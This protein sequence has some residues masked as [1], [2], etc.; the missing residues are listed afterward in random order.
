MNKARIDLQ[1]MTTSLVQCGQLATIIAGLALVAQGSLAAE[2]A[3]YLAWDQDAGA[4]LK[5]ARATVFLDR[6][7]R[8]PRPV[9]KFAAGK[10]VLLQKL[11]SES[12]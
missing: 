1:V 4:V 6:N 2:R 12:D 9:L 5:R 10:E 11:A 7:D 3:A 8:R